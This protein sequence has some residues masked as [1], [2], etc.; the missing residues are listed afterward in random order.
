MTQNPKPPK[1]YT[2]KNPQLQYLSRTVIVNL[3]VA[4][5]RLEQTLRNPALIIITMI[6]LIIVIV[7]TIAIISSIIA[8]MII[9]N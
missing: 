3:L 8:M 5:C 2:P 4:P 7:V 9:V 6:S 1:L